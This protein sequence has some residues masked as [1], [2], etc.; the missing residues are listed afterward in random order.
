[1]WNTTRPRTVAMIFTF[2]MSSFSQSSLN[3]CCQWKGNEGSLYLSC[4]L[5]TISERLCATPCCVADSFNC[6][7]AFVV[8][9]L[10]THLFFL[11]VGSLDLANIA[12]K[13]LWHHAITLLAKNLETVVIIRYAT[14]PM[15]VNCLFLLSSCPVC[16]CC[17]RLRWRHDD[18]S[19]FQSALYPPPS[20]QQLRQWLPRQFGRRL[21]LSFTFFLFFEQMY[22]SIHW[23]AAL[24]V[25]V[26]GKWIHCYKIYTVS[27]KRLSY[28]KNKQGAVF[29]HSV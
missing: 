1:M 11:F 17:S 16:V 4:S 8:C 21:G 6:T 13:W 5:H 24:R 25:T 27:Q 26:S 7:P 29:R 9:V 28:W 14:S 2:M 22:R 23:R 10:L 12:R 3:S 19:L 20:C 18:V 15:N